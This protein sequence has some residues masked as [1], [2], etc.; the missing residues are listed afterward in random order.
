MP[1]F[2]LLWV[3]F[4]ILFTTPRLSAGP[5]AD[6]FAALV[7]E[8]WQ[9]RLEQEPLFATS[10]GEHRYNH[11]L[12]SV[13]QADSARRNA[14]QIAFL[15]RLDQIERDK[16][17][18]GDRNSFD[19]LRRQITEDLAEFDFGSHLMPITQRTGFHIGFPELPKEVPLGTLADF[20]NYIARLRG[21]GDYVDGHIGL[22]RQGLVAERMLPAIAWEGWQQSVDAQIT[23]DPRSSLLYEPLKELPTAVPAGEHD[24]LRAEAREAISSTVVPGYRRFRKFMAQ[25]YV[26]GG[27]DSI[28]ISAVAGGRDFYR[29]RVRKYTTLDLSPE[30]V[31]QTGLVE[32]K[33]IRAE[34][35]QII[36]RVKFEGDF[37]AFTKFLRE[38]PQFYA[39]SK[40]ELLK[41]VSFALKKMD[42]QLPTLFRRLPRMPYGL[43]EV[44]EYIA[45]RTTAAYYQRPTGDGAKAGF[46]YMNTY[47]LKSRPLFTVEAL[48]LHEA[49]PGHHLQLALQQEIE[50]LPHFRRFGGFTAFIEGWALYAERL[51]LEVGFYEDPYSDFGRLTM[52][53]WRACRLVVDTGIHFKGWTREQAI[54]FMSSNSAMSLHNI[55]AEVDRY[56]TWPGQALAYKTGEMKIRQLRQQA[57]AKLGARFDVRAFHEVVL[58]SGA[59][60]LDVLEANVEAWIES[61]GE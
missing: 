5:A 22:M 25:E 46:Y 35:D 38:D 11:L 23:D 9:Y 6:E 10:V 13:S 42:G 48:S 55:R 61:G 56:I 52:E 32:V 53:I 57:E 15:K 18:T 28:G 20:E 54:D 37:E 41:E 21:F 19:I 12:P 14:A 39:D 17:S 36:R 60:P 1:R 3:L 7:D 50:D 26:P 44:P 30:E 27:R 51:G 29:H 4:L 33:R 45:P 58:G 8:M 49:V 31:H 34:M 47:N 2:T 40:E 43:R 16:L 24:R 59:V